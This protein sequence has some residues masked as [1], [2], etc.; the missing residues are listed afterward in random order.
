MQAELNKSEKVLVAKVLKR[1]GLSGPFLKLGKNTTGFVNKIFIVENKNQKFALRQSA[2]QTSLSHLKFE[3]AVL[4]YLE[5]KSFKFTPR[6][7]SNIA[8]EKATKVNGCYFILQNFL[9]GHWR[10]NWN[11]LT[12]YNKAMLR[13]HFALLALFSKQISAFNFEKNKHRLGLL[14]YVGNAEKLLNKSISALPASK[15]KSFMRKNQN[16][17]L[18]FALETRQEML[19]VG[20]DSLPKQI[21][22][23]D[24]HPGNL[25]FLKNRAVAMFDFDWVR[26]DNRLSDL[27]AALCESCYYYHGSKAGYYRKDRIW[28]AI[29]SYHQ[30]YGKSEFKPNKEIKLTKIAFKACLFFQILACLDWYKEH[31][32]EKRSDFILKFFIKVMTVNDFERLFG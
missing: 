20:Y 32:K 18:S 26:Y 12:T 27:A 11:N 15:G 3:V 14:S 30:A 21:V 2:E 17:I 4:D 6:V 13:S 1:Y 7:L 24:L 16:L 25:H 22:H 29:N 19:Q 28:A 10:A 23:F 8:G 31:Y 5:K 9:P